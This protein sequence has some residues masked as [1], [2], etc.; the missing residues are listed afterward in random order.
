MDGELSVARPVLVVNTR[1]CE[2]SQNRIQGGANI[3]PASLIR[4]R[5]AIVSANDL[6]GNS[7]A[8][9]LEI[10]V[11]EKTAPVVGNLRTGPITIN[12]A[13]LAAP[14]E[15]LNPISST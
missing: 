14:W 6:R 8:I 12:G 9:V 3:G 4:S 11:Q 2:L 1:L 13:A 10:V 5:R 7:D 15:P